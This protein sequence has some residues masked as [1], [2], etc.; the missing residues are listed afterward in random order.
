MEGEEAQLV[1]MDPLALPNPFTLQSFSRAKW[2]YM[3]LFGNQVQIFLEF[4]FSVL[5]VRSSSSCL[6]ILQT[7]RNGTLLLKDSHLILVRFT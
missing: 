2:V 4:F 1:V 7:Q 6:I 5:S 3:M